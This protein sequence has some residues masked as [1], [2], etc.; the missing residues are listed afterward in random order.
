MSI[1]KHGA[2]EAK[3]AK[4]GYYSAD[5]QVKAA[6]RNSCSFCWFVMSIYPT[7]SGMIERDSETYKLHLQKAHGLREEIRA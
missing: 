7:L 2:D 6:S 3:R 4:K 1:F 5:V